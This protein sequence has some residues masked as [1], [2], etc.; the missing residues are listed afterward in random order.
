MIT[1]I[2]DFTASRLP[3]PA[4][5]DARPPTAD[6]GFRPLLPP[7]P[8]SHYGRRVCSIDLKSARPHHIL[9]RQLPRG[10]SV[11]LKT[12]S[13]EIVNRLR[14]GYLLTLGNPCRLT[15]LGPRTVLNN[16]AIPR[17]PNLAGVGVELWSCSFH[18]FILS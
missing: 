5:I 4:S 18:K 6:A 15:R 11:L 7:G 10:S 2:A 3:D 13:F 12:F 1:F 16:V 14:G 17:G 9:Q 8:T